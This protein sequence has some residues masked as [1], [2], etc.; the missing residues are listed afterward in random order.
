MDNE[1]LR[2]ARLAMATARRVVPPRLSRHA[3]PVYHPASLMAALL[4]KEH[5]RLSI[6]D[7][8]SRFARWPSDDVYPSPQKAHDNP[9]HHARTCQ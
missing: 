7:L 9:V 8:V 6:L 4:L 5:L 1:L 3:D 2:F